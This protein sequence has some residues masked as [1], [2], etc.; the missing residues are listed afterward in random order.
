MAER[1]RIV[2]TSKKKRMPAIHEEISQSV[3]SD[4]E[5][6]KERDIISGK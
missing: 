3:G 6:A 5:I 4:R 2:R 1:I